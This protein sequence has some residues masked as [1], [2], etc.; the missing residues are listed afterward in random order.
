MLRLRGVEDTLRQENRNHDKNIRMLQQVLQ[1]NNIPM[2]QDFYNPMTPIPSLT[3]FSS[4]SARDSSASPAVHVDL[5]SLGGVE[6]LR[7]APIEQSIEVP[8]Y[9]SPSST[10]MDSD[11]APSIAT[12]A[13]P[14]NGSG[15]TTG[16]TVDLTTLATIGPIKWCGQR[17]AETPPLEYVSPATFF[18]QQGGPDI[19]MP[20]PTLD[21]QEAIDF[22]LE[23]VFSTLNL[24]L[25]RARLMHDSRLEK[26]CLP[27]VKF[28]YEQEKA[29]PYGEVTYNAGPGHVFM[30]TTALVNSQ[31]LFDHAT[32]APF[33]L[34]R[35]N[36]DQLFY[37]SMSIDF[38]TD[39]TPVQIWANIVR[40]CASRNGLSRSLLRAITDE[41][42]KYVR[43]NS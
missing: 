9:H 29:P 5:T 12:Y 20:P 18:G 40:I 13:N 28:Q 33:E 42:N 17:A 21:S 1:A 35:A 14:S 10:A 37:T 11:F 27:H 30:A 16:V 2:P 25:L 24:P 3:P 34:P 15:S 36:I 43:C 22:I 32:S 19:N 8:T 41:F 31:G 4:P 6:A 23:Y 39:V 7:L 26:P 38:M